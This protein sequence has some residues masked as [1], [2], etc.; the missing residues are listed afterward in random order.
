MNSQKHSTTKFKPYEVLFK[1]PMFDN[2][3]GITQRAQADIENEHMDILRAND[4][5]TNTVSELVVINSRR[6]PEKIIS[7]V[8]EHGNQPMSL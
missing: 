2:L 1:Q 5:T 4:T 7:R 6:A 8:S 3:L